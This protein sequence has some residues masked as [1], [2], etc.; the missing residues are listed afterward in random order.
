MQVSDY[1][2]IVYQT[3]KVSIAILV[4][5]LGVVWINQQAFNE[6]WMLHFHRETPWENTDAHWWSYGATVGNALNSSEENFLKVLSGEKDDPAPAVP[7]V[8]VKSADCSA[9]SLPHPSPVMTASNGP[10][11]AIPPS[12][13]QSQQPAAGSSPELI[14]VLGPMKT[15]PEKVVLP[16]GKKVLMIGDSMMEGVA[17]QIISLLKKEHQIGGVNLSKRSTGLAYPSF[18][19]WPKTTE[20]A[21]VR[22]PDIGLLIVFMGPNDPWDMPSERNRHFLKFK[23]A[24]WE[25]EY[26]QR[27]ER[28]LASAQQRN[29]P[30]IWALPPVMRKSKLNA[31]VSY[32]DTLYA[33]EVSNSGGVTVDVNTLFGY[34]DNHYSPNAVIDGKKMRVRADDGIHYSPEGQRLIA[35]AIL[36]KIQFPEKNKE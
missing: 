14:S 31:G 19:N 17:P 32:L 3:I 26:R 6:Y 18:F 22:E 34:K 21:L 36:T 12:D 27:I 24:E 7:P 15:S 4:S 35:R 1:S 33:S 10:S 13:A 29:I 9:L 23:S 20:N 30:V 8:M 2:H 5:A 16:A 28:I 11:S 25:S